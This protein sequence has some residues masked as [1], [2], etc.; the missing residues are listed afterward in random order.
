MAWMAFAVSAVADTTAADSAAKTKD[1]QA[2]TVN[3]NVN[4]GATA[5]ATAA[6]T[7]TNAAQATQPAAPA[8]PT[9]PAEKKFD[10]L[11]KAR[12]Q[13]EVKNDNKV[14][15]KLEKTRLEDEKQLSKT[16]ESTDLKPD[17]NAQAVKIEKVEV[18]QP[19]PAPTQAAPLAIE[20][21][22]EEPK[23]EE[24]KKEENKKWYAGAGFGNIV[25]NGNVITKSDYG[26]VAGTKL[27]D[28]L[29]IEGSL[30]VSSFTLNNYWGGVITN[31]VFGSMDQYDFAVTAKYL[32]LDN[33]RFHPYVGGGLD[34]IYRQYKDRIPYTVP[35]GYDNYTSQETTNAFNASLVGGLDINLTSRF[36]I[37]G[38]FRYSLPVYRQDNGLITASYVMQNAKPL[39]ESNFTSWLLTVKFL[40]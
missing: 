12:A 35:W 28:H 36:L 16:I 38:E 24:P 37:G 13:E 26:V 30:N 18:I 3:V 25:Y 6:P 32:F 10:E 11:R 15:E 33:E 34:Y 29:V 40:F 7:A 1:S 19:A 17:A 14:V 4:D 27:D 9:S 2:T 31:G 39:E 8:A 23:K 21:K 22:K 5:G 20:E